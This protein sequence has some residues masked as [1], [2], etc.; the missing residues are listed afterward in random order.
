MLRV[1][2]W[3]PGN[4]NGKRGKG[5]RKEGRQGGVMVGRK[6]G[7]KEGRERKKESNNPTGPN[8]SVPVITL[9]L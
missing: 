3:T 1:A 2:F 9:L 8:K 7:R 4:I 6:E 5:G